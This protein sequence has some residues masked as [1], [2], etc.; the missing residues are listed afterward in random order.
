[1]T[2]AFKMGSSFAAFHFALV[3]G[4][5]VWI[6]THTARDPQAPMLWLLVGLLDFPAYILF[7]AFGAQLQALPRVEW[8]PQK[9]GSWITGEWEPFLAPLLVFAVLGTV[10]WF[11]IGWG[12]GRVWSFRRPRA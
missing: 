11:L 8:L 3:L 5:A 7:A 12:V 2:R 9:T 6:A 4:V 1:M 10:W